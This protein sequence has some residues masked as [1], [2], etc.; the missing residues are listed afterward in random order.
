MRLSTAAASCASG[1][2]RVYQLAVYHCVFSRYNLDKV[3][4]FFVLLANDLDQLVDGVGVVGDWAERAARVVVNG[5]LVA[6]R[7]LMA[8]PLM[9]RRG[10]ISP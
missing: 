9:R 6:A 8:L 7:M 4:T 2:R 1:T 3:G 10:L 5:V